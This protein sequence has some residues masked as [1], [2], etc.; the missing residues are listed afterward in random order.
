MDS[1][2]FPWGRAGLLEV[3]RARVARRGL[4][5]TARSRTSQEPPRDA[6]RARVAVSLL[7]SRELRAGSPLAPLEGLCAGS[8]DP[9]QVSTCASEERAPRERGRERR[10]WTT[11]AAPRSRL[12]QAIQ[13]A[14]CTL[15]GEPWR[16]AALALRPGGAAPTS[17]GPRA[18]SES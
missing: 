2:A 17:G 5:H 1:S 9:G 16:R 3:V 8:R 13:R 4:E 14:A 15:P 18:G 10:D 11:T 7:P 12:L 6:R